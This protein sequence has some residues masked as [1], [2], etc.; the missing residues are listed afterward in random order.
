MS[1][2][3]NGITPMLEIFDLPTSIAFYRDILGFEV[4]SEAR[5]WC[6]LQLGEVTL[7]LNTAYDDDDERP[8]QPDPDRVRNHADTYLYFGSSDPDAV[9]THLQA[10]GWPATAPVVT[11]YGMREVSTRD[12]DGFG[13]FFNA[14]LR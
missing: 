8:P 12:P 10:K 4:V 2:T 6:R 14:P 1:I 3:L 7:M 5:C 13:L 9:Y 11:S